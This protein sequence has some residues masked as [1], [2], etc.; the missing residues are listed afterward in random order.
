[1]TDP[2]MLTNR[3]PV[4]ADVIGEHRVASPE[5]V[6]VTMHAARRAWEDWKDV[7]PAGRADILGLIRERIV[8]RTPELVEAISTDT[9]KV[10][11]EA[12]MADIYPTLELIKYYEG[13]LERILRPERRS[14]P[15]PLGP[16]GY[17]EYFPRG[18]VAVI[19]PWNYPFQLCVMPIIT[20]LAAGNAAVLKP[21]EVSP[22]VG[23]TIRDLF[24]NVPGMPPGLVGVLQGEG[25]VGRAIIDAGPDM[26]FFTGSVATGK[27]VMEAAARQMIPVLLELGGK[28]AFIVLED[29]NLQRAAAGAVYAAFANTGQL[30]VSA[31]RVYVHRAVISEFSRLVEEETRRLRVNVGPDGDLGPLTHPDGGEHVLHHIRDALD[32]GARILGDAGAYSPERMTEM[33][34]ALSPCIL[35]D[36]D[37]SMEVMVDETFGPVMPIMAFSDDAE[38]VALANDSRYGLNASVWSRDIRRARKMA[39]ML[40]VGSC[41]INDVVGNGGRPELPFGGVKESGIGRYHGPEGLKNFS[42]TRSVVIHR[43]R[44]DAELNWFPFDP[45]VYE[46]LSHFIRLRFSGSST[47]EKIL[48]LPRFLLRLATKGKD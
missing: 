27:S 24:E 31:E 16:K 28:D 46:N 39:G 5:D 4:T 19:G 47:V 36:V 2:R 30:C 20:A 33:G 18:V 26:I 23:E 6:E 3:D 43:G 40:E 13:N 17:V 41:S 8:A 14:S 42:N 25:E 38:A 22:L 10:R 37:H 12:L 21:S 15:L 29:A 48:S 1:M 32:K 9:G 35:R 45:G 44:R 11:L 7:R 34:N